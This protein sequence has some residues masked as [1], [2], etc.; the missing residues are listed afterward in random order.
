MTPSLCNIRG[1]WAS[2]NVGVS[3]DVVIKKL[4]KMA[5][6]GALT[7]EAARP[8]SCFRLYSTAPRRVCTQR[9]ISTKSGNISLSYS[10]GASLNDPPPSEGQE[11]PT[12]HTYS[13]Y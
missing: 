8:I 12:G 6:G 7:L 10:A 5:T 13:Y 1:G 3:N 4:K 9:E 2:A 11:L